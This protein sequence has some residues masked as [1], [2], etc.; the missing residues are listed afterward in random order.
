MEQPICIFETINK[1]NAIGNSGQAA[2]DILQSADVAEADQAA[3]V[4]CERCGIDL[5]ISTELG[6]ERAQLMLRQ[7]SSESPDACAATR[8]RK[9]G[10]WVTNL[11]NR[12][13]TVD[14]LQSDENDIQASEEDIHFDTSTRGI[15][16][17][18]YDAVSRAKIVRE[19][20]NNPAIAAA[21]NIPK[22]E[23]ELDTIVNTL[24]LV[25]VRDDGKSWREE[26]EG[27]ADGK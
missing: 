24:D 14:L 1:A 9:E 16:I 17:A 10:D 7:S 25:L 3:V 8:Y 12:W 13:F 11:S 27:R 15:G 22:L 5:E 20:Q 2:I 19:A 26:I 18:L 6:E 4:S 23:C 21:H